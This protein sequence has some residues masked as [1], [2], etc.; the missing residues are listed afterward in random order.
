MVWFALLPDYCTL[1]LGCLSLSA[2]VGKSRNYEIDLGQRFFNLTEF[3]RY[4]SQ[5]SLQNST[6]LIAAV[7]L[8][9]DL[10]S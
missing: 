10:A 6:F 4:L 1:C 5:N 7:L 2:K 8:A 9:L 3:V